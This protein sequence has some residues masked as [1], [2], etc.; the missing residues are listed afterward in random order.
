MYLCHV[1]H[2]SH[3]S[4]ALQLELRYIRLQQHVNLRNKD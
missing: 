2:V 4:K 1:D 3:K